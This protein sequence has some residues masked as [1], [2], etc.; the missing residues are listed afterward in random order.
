MPAFLFLK[1][2]IDMI[3][4]VI[5]EGVVVRS[6]SLADD[7]LYRIASYRDPSLPPKPSDQP[8]A[9]PDFVTVRVRNGSLGGPVSFRDQDVV[10]VHGL[11]RSRHY[12]ES[13]A[14]FAR[15]AKGPRLKLL[16]DYD[17]RALRRTQVATEIPALAIVPL[18][19]GPANRN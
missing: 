13:L 16:D 3:N 1:G 8:R 18:E 15:E 7:R 9:A 4:T 12:E 11:I 5:L 10:R 2:D 6:C 19:K 14:D 17:A